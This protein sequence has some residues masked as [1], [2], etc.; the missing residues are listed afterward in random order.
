MAGSSAILLD[1]FQLVTISVAHRSFG[2]YDLDDALR[3][4]IPCCYSLWKR[5]GVRASWKR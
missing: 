2:V 3:I 4:D 5:A 1:P